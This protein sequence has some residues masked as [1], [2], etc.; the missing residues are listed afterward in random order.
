MRTSPVKRFPRRENN[1]LNLYARRTDCPPGLT[2][3]EWLTYDGRRMA[4]GRDKRKRVAKRKKDHHLRRVEAA[5]EEPP[6]GA[7]TFDSFVYAPLKPKPHSNAGAIALDQ[8]EEP[9]PESAIGYLKPYS[10]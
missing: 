7:D 2:L 4:K 6:P 9:E 3:S 5:P 8:P 10:L 1:L